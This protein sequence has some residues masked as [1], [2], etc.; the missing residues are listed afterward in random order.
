MLATPNGEGVDESAKPSDVVGCCG[1]VYGLGLTLVLAPGTVHPLLSLGPYDNVTT[2][3]FGAAL[4]GMMATFVIAAHDPAK[5]IVRA[6]ATGMAFVGFTA[7]YEM[8][9]V[10]PTPLSLY[11]VGSLAIDLVC[12][13]VLF[14]P[15]ARPDLAAKRRLA[16]RSRGKEMHGAGEIICTKPFPLARETGSVGFKPAGYR[17]LRAWLA[18]LP[19]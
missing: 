13:G 4:L 15:E 10:K 7:A 9:I 6:S 17:R 18:A 14:L 3:M 1:V 2:A 11:T 12:C 16:A 19:V 8:F 5:E